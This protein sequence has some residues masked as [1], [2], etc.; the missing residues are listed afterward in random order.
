MWCIR[1]GARAK[2]VIP[3]PTLYLRFFLC[4]KF[5]RLD[6]EV[7]ILPASNDKSPRRPGT[8]MPYS[9]WAIAIGRWEHLIEKRLLLQ[10]IMLN[11]TN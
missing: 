8:H 11:F 6:Y 7:R 1:S 10:R 9:E 4:S 2:R 3:I 5:K